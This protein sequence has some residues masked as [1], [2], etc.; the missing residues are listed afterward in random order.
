MNAAT[1]HAE[2][3]THRGVVSF[4][5]N[6]TVMDLT[7]PQ[8]SDIDFADMAGTLGKIARFNGICRGPAYSVAQHC[9]MGADALDHETGDKILAGYFLLHDGHEYRFGDWTRP[10]VMAIAHRA[11][12]IQP[13]AGTAIVIAI[14]R[15]KDAIDHA[16][17][18]AAGVAPLHRVPLYARQ[19]K[20]MD[21][22]M[23]RAE[24]LAL[25]GPKAGQH[26][27][28]ANRPPPRVTGSF[29]KPWPAEK[30]REAFLDRLERY[31]GIVA[32]H[33]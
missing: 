2:H 5:P 25:F 19:V 33:A 12:A 26:L 22:R 24:G 23:L 20:D 16:I 8:A 7:D 17:W 13:G 14:E 6:G 11:E 31:L 10:S 28:A 29:H 15:Q 4:N 3:M 30:A 18:D 27:P 1:R 9:V 21:A 32:R